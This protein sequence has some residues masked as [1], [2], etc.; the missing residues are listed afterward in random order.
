MEINGKCGK[1]TYSGIQRTHID[2]MIIRLW[3]NGA[4][5]S[6]SNPW[7]VVTHKFGIVLQGNW[8]AQQELLDVII[9]KKD[10]VVSCEKLWENLDRLI[11][12]VKTGTTQL[13]IDTAV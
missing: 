12:G 10:F 3:S 2:D 6:D 7:T 13:N 5:V 4:Y 9:L 11:A 1:R 8:D